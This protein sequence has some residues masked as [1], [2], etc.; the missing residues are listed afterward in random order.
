MKWKSYRTSSKVSHKTWKTRFSRIDRTVSKITA[1]IDDA[2]QNLENFQTQ[3]ARALV[4][5]Q[6]LLKEGSNLVKSVASDNLDLKLGVDNEMRDVQ[7][8]AQQVQFVKR[9]GDFL[10]RIEVPEEEW[11]QEVEFRTG[12]VK[13]AKIVGST[14]KDEILVKN[15]DDNAVYAVSLK[16]KSRKKVI[17]KGWYDVWQCATLDDGRIFFGTC[18]GEITSFD[19]NWR[20]LESSILLVDATRDQKTPVF[21]STRKDGMILATALGGSSIKVINPG[22]GDIVKEMEW[23][24][25]IYGMQLLSTDQIVIVTECAEGIDLCV[26]NATGAAVSSTHLHGQGIKG[27]AVDQSSDTIYCLIYDRLCDD[28]ALDVMSPQGDV[29]GKRVV[30]F[31]PSYCTPTLVVTEPGKLAVH[32]DGKIVVY[33]K[34]AQAY[35]ERL[36]KVIAGVQCELDL[37][38][39]QD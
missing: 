25:P 29:L 12:T 34:V 37:E 24:Y 26:L 30:K 5:D 31:Q 1:P 32:C 11:K 36:R 8:I 35:E 18:D 28:F 20:W 21:V 13:C 39:G 10:G 3:A 16:D 9:K 6:L 22:N 19:Q 27:F 2:L 17:K 38:I 23:G 7:D 4:D 15:D 33:Q 14:N